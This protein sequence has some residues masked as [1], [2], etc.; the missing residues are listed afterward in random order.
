MIIYQHCMTISHYTLRE[1]CRRTLPKAQ[2]RY[3]LLMYHAKPVNSSF[4]RHFGML[5]RGRGLRMGVVGVEKLRRIGRRWCRACIALP[6]SPRPPISHATHASVG[7]SSQA[8][9]HPPTH[10]LTHPLTHS[11]THSPT[12]SLTHS[13]TH[14]RSQHPQVRCPRGVQ[15]LPRG[16]RLSQAQR[17][18]SL[19][20]LHARAGPSPQLHHAINITGC[21]APA[22]IPRGRPSRFAC[23]CHT[24]KADALQ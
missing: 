3:C 4:R 7:L 9:T 13:L 14:H 18:A 2:C 6:R 8:L 11:L 16:A 21:A 12:H 24:A 22:H 17:L 23:A 5:T 20:D 19:P 15:S 1:D 10:L